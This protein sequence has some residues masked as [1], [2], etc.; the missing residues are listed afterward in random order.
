[1]K[2]I[3]VILGYNDHGYNKFTPITN[4][5]RLIIWSQMAACYN[6]QDYNDVTV[7]MNKYL[8][9]RTVRYKRV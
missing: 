1:M 8:R 3:I 4:K 2:L 9:S 7:K 5:I 6:L